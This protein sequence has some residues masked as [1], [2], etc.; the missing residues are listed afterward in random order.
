MGA[1]INNKIT[2]AIR[3]ADYVTYSFHPVK[4]ITTGEGGAVITNN[5]FVDSKI[6]QL[7][8]HGITKNLKKICGIMI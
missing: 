2:Y 4:P 8:T 3:Y 1:E 5:K 7:R 6:K